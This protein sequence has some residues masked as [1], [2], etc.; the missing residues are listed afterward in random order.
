MSH[1]MRR[2]TS[3]ST[4]Q[5]TSAAWAN[6]WTSLSS[7]SRRSCAQ[8]AA[9]H[10]Q[11]RSQ[12][13]QTQVCT[14]SDMLDMRMLVQVTYELEVHRASA[15]LSSR[16]DDKSRRHTSQAGRPTPPRLA[17]DCSKHEVQKGANTSNDSLLLAGL[18]Y[19]MNFRV[20]A[21]ARAR[22]SP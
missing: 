22:S 15:S 13:P 4:S 12:A 11:R 1:G 9:L 6:F 17:Q 14:C 16:S 8:E 2:W 5:K 21:S 18:C 20:L 3:S 7:M 10:L 19:D